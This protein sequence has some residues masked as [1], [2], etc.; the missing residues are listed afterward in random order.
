MR[1]LNYELHKEG[2]RLRGAAAW[3]RVVPEPRAGYRCWVGV[4]RRQRA[5]CSVRPDAQGRTAVTLPQLPVLG[6]GQ[7]EAAGSL[8][9]PS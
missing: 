7:A 4:R 6:R 3:R 9:P 1:K 8:L 2:A 5:V